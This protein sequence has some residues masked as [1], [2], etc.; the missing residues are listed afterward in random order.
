MWDKD[1]RYTEIRLDSL[2]TAELFDRSADPREEVNLASER[3]DIVELYSGALDLRFGP[4][5]RLVL[6]RGSEP[7]PVELP[8]G[9][10]ERLRALGYVGGSGN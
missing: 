8:L 1:W 6:E 2:L 3:P 9:V 7:E 4:E 10:E 5:R